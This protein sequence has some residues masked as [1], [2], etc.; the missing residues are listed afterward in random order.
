VVSSHQPALSTRC[1]VVSSSARPGHNLYLLSFDILLHSFAIFCPLQI[2]IPHVFKG[3]C[4]LAAKHQGVGVS[5]AD[6]KLSLRSDVHPPMFALDSQ[7]SVSSTSVSPL[8]AALVGASQLTEIPRTLSPVF[9]TLTPSVTLK[10]FHCHSY[11]KLPGVG[12]QRTGTHT[13]QAGPGHIAHAIS[14]FGVAA[15]LRAKVQAGRLPGAR[16]Q[17]ARARPEA[18]SKGR[19]S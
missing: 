5:A 9:A 18:C 15:A 2:S 4:A 8:F 12:V 7:P 11:T 10:S 1:A 6:R 14:C 13:P 16:V 3:F 19:W 17:I